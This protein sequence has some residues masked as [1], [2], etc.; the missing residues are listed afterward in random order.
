MDETDTLK[1]DPF[2]LLSE[3]CNHFDLAAKGA[4]EA[5]G[6]PLAGSVASMAEGLRLM[7]EAMKQLFEHRMGH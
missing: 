1:T 7:G 2:E 6:S 5:A 4:H 3:A